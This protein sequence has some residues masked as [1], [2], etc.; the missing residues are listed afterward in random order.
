MTLIRPL[1]FLG[2]CLSLAFLV[3]PA[4]AAESPNIVEISRGWQ[5]T[6][7]SN[8]TDDLAPSQPGYDAS[9]W[10]P[11]KHMPA[12]VLQV[13]E[14]AG[15][16]PDLYFGMNLAKPGDLWKQDWWYRTTFTVPA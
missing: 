9:K 8:V 6:S 16:Y 11:I 1:L 15:V 14:D 10:Y 2:L 13:L 3:V 7:A 5:M 12:T 4:N